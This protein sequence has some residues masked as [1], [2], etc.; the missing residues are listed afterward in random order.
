MMWQGV[1]EFLSKE[2]TSITL[3]KVIKITQFYK[4]SLYLS[5]QFPFCLAQKESPLL[6]TRKGY[7]IKYETVGSLWFAHGNLQLSI[8]L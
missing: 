2:R 6:L 1:Y 4:T 7:S 5:L 3:T 8:R